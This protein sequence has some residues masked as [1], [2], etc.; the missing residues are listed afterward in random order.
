[1]TLHHNDSESESDHDEEVDQLA[2]QL[3]VAD[4]DVST[5]HPLS[6]EVISKQVSSKQFGVLEMILTIQ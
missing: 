6:P 2:E 3:Q 1:M 5:L 4:I